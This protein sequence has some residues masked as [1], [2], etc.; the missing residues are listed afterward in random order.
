MGADLPGRRIVRTV[1]VVGCGLIGRAW[2][3]AFARGGF[4]VRLW[5]PDGAAVTAALAFA[6][7]T[8]AELARFGLVEDPA[9]AAA[10]LRP[11]ATPEEVLAGAAYVQE[12]AP[13]REEVKRE[14]FR[15]LDALAAPETVLASSSSSLPASV[16][17]ADLPGRGRC[18]V[19]H[20]VNPPC[21][22]P[23]VEL[24]PA[25]FTTPAA[26]ARA[27]E[28]MV[29]AGQVPVRLR[30]EIRGFVLNR[31]QAALLGEAFALVR[32]GVVSVEDLDRTVRDG[33]GLRWA[34][35]GP[36]E[37]IDLNAPGGVRD[38]ATRYGAMLA[39][40]QRPRARPEPWEEPLVAEVE[41]QRRARLPAARLAE[42]ARWRDRRLMALLAHRRE[43]DR[44]FGR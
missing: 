3:V 6:R 9:E 2:A 25:P 44:R 36:F 38:Y 40:L 14:L 15:R 37:T 35:M 41:R 31:L 23:V 18:L 22:V 26:L 13:E 8:L 16:F 21:L 24:V 27:E 17:A 42:R 10:R 30:R 29:R 1:A 39:E 32:E 33:L 19:A 11:A 5:D 4:E 34:F 7:E 28:V 20:P 12:S 43:A